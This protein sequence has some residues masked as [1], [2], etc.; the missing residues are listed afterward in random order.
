VE[1]D[2]SKISKN[3]RAEQRGATAALTP[4]VCPACHERVPQNQLLVVMPYTGG[5]RGR[6]QGYHQG[7]YRLAS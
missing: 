3:A 1:R 6:T 4:H 7:C 2:R 5:K